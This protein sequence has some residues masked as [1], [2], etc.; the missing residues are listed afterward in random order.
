MRVNPARR[1]LHW[2][3]GVSLLAT[4]CGIFLRLSYPATTGNFGTVLAVLGT[5][6][7]VLTGFANITNSSKNRHSKASSSVTI[8][9][10]L[11]LLPTIMGAIGVTLLLTGR[12][13]L[14]AAISVGALLA[15]PLTALLSV[16]S[17][18]TGKSRKS[19]ASLT[20]LNTLWLAVSMAALLY[21][22]WV[23]STTSFAD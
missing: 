15:V 13:G 4:I 11:A 17:A 21:L 18:F 10:A 3:P 19:K 6:A 7:L 8:G 9:E 1:V 12:P 5:V 22:C 20:I 2:L 16:L 23:A 14:W